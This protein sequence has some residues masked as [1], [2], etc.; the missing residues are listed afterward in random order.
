VKKEREELSSMLKKQLVQLAATAQVRVT[1]RV[2]NKSRQISKPMMIRR[3]IGAKFGVSEQQSAPTKLSAKTIHDKFRL[4][5]CLFSDEIGALAA[6]AE[7]VSRADLDTGAVGGNS[8]YWKVVEKRFN[9]GFPDN[10]VDGPVFADILCIQVSKNIMRQS[11]QPSMG[12]SPQKS[13]GRCGRKYRRIM[14][15]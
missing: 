4:L 7:D 13:F 15:K 5:N 10:S 1:H 9:E 2:D 6:T 3:L 14:T 11:T 8:S 12:H